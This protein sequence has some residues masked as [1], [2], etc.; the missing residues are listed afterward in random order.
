MFLGLNA[1][2]FPNS[3]TALKAMLILFDIGT[4]LLILRLLKKKRVPFGSSAS[5][6]VVPLGD[7]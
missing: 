1:T 5:L 2:L 7:L 4:I 6:R 3:I